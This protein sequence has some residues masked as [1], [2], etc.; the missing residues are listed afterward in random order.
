MSCAQ[1]LDQIYL[2]NEQQTTT[3]KMQEYPFQPNQN[4][5]YTVSLHPYAKELEE[6]IA[7]R[8]A[9]IQNYTFQRPMMNTGANIHEN[10][11]MVDDQLRRP[12]TSMSQPRHVP[13]CEMGRNSTSDIHLPI[14]ERCITSRLLNTT[15]KK[16]VLAEHDYY[17]FTPLVPA[18]QQFIRTGVPGNNH[19]IGEPS[20]SR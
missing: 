4:S 10:R 13:F 19:L 3:N 15:T 14:D 17:R 2:C 1:K 18:V 5:A 8:N 11:I 7:R 9:S 12:V 20:I 16:E 6:D